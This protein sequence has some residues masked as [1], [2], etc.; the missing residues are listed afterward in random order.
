M[1]FVCVTHITGYEQ[2]WE[3]HLAQEEVKGQAQ[4]S[5][6]ALHLV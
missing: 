4:V 5:I 2:T 3:C 1:L 6:L